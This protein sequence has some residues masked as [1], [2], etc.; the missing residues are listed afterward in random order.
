MRKAGLEI[1]LVNS[2]PATIMTD[3]ETADRVY[4]EPLEVNTLEKIIAREKPDGLLATL[5][6]QT[7]LNLSMELYRKGIL[8]KYECK[9][10]GTGEEAIRKGEDREE[11][12]QAMNN[13]NVPVPK[14]IIAHSYEEVIGF[15]EKQS[16]PLIVRPA[17]TLGGTGGGIA[18]TQTELKRLVERGLNLSPIRQVL[19][20]EALVPKEGWGE[21]EFEVMR[22]KLDSCIIVCS[23]ENLDPMG[24]H[25]GDSIV[26]APIQTLNNGEY[27]ELR[28]AAIR[29]IRELGIEGGCNV[30]FAFNYLTREYRVIEVNP[31]VSRSSSLASKA[32][33]YPIAKVAALISV[34]FTLDE[35]R[36]EVT[37]KTSCAFEP[38]LDYVVVKIPRW[39]FD[40]FKRAE[41]KIGTQM[42]STGEAMAIARTFEQAL[43]KACRAV[44]NGRELCF[45][46]SA[47]PEERLE[48]LI[49]EGNSERIYAISQAFRNGWGVKRVAELSGIHEWFLSKIERIV[50]HGMV[51]ERK[52]QWL[53]E[54]KKLGFSD[55]QIAFVL[56]MKETEVMK[57]RE[58]LS[59]KPSFFMV[60]TCAGE[61]ES[62]TPYLYSSYEKSSDNPITEKKKVLVIG[63]GPIRIGQGIEFDYC[64]VHAVKAIRE[65][66]LEALIINSNPETVSTDFDV[67][68]KLFFEPLTF[69]DVMNVI[70]SEKP[71]GVI[72][73]MGGQTSVNLAMKLEKEGVK[74]LGTSAAD[75]DKAE[76]RENFSNLLKELGISQPR[77]SFVNSLGE[78]VK[79][80]HEI[81]FPL[82]ARPSYVLGGRGMEIVRNVEQLEDY[83]QEAT[84]VSPDHPLRVDEYLE[85]AIE[86]DVDLLCDSED[87]WVAGVMQH[88]EEAGVHSGDATCVL[89]PHNL[90]EK[91]VEEIEEASKKIALAL[92]VKGLVNVQVAVRGGEIFVFEANPRASR[93][94][95]FLSKALGVPIAR[96]GTKIMLGAKLSEF[97]LPDYN[98]MKFTAVKE[99]VFSFLKLPGVDSFLTP[100]MK[101]TGE[102]MGCGQG[103]EEALWKAE[104]SAGMPLPEKGGILLSAGSVEDKE[105][106]IPLSKKLGKLGFKLYATSGTKTSLEENGINA[107]EVGKIHEGS[108]DIPLKLK[109]K[110]ISLV[111]TTGFQQVASEGYL[112]RRACIENNVPSITTLEGIQASIGALEHKVGKTFEV[113]TIKE[114]RS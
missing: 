86:V 39:P 101:S 43:Q 19:V 83:L 66:G 74:V 1:V 33:A 64:S 34:G 57:W 84:R 28:S 60:D 85:D 67:S 6:G 62:F 90:S 48:E 70:E 11:F 3:D 53:A 82:L 72:V 77:S 58:K 9:F 108:E 75:M 14:S 21:M 56:K 24:V 109:S 69:E 78:A 95:P 87:A 63:S 23:M 20:E 91:T 54:A 49:S 59:L 45:D 104:L 25:T 52:E 35:I 37:K 76:N 46:S 36:N 114:Y 61:F 38:A 15:S 103:F 111:L 10:L 22:D 16:L 41:K 5:G 88:V 44:E 12:K 4:I 40:K 105:A 98:E 13:C 17:Y 112:L 8:Q 71:L 100:E 110:E 96:I 97:A 30:Q 26:V 47:F 93:T 79:S 2:N 102:V 80:A 50:K 81:G 55:K 99:S 68:D 113:K 65:R 32:T 51:A 73:Q 31:R 27:Q 107:I 89:P 7:A 42:K 92:N 18:L 94:V 29:I 106:F